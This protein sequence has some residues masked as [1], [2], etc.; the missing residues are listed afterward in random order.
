MSG[1]E[2]LNQAAQIIEEYYD[3]LNTI[4]QDV[5]SGDGPIADTLEAIDLLVDYL[6]EEGIA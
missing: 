1:I 4:R 2:R 6:A 5:D 3:R